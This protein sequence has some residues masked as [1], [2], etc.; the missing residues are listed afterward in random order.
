LTPRTGIP[1]FSDPGNQKLESDPRNPKVDSDRWFLK[2]EGIGRGRSGVSHFGIYKRLHTFCA[3]KKNRSLHRSLTEPALVDALSADCRAFILKKDFPHFS[4]TPT[5][6]P[7]GYQEESAILTVFIDRGCY[8]EDPSDVRPVPSP[9][10]QQANT[11][12]TQVPSGLL[13]VLRRVRSRNRLAAR[14]A[15]IVQQRMTSHR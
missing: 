7:H 9:S 3:Q 4:R 8:L 6:D 15:Q 11:V 12:P 1:D 2:D 10:L 5:N 13:L 14:I